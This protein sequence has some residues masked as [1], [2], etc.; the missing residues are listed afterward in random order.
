MKYEL[1]HC[2]VLVSINFVMLLLHNSEEGVRCLTDFCFRVESLVLLDSSVFVN[3]KS[4][5][6]K[7]SVR[8]IVLVIL[9]FLQ[10]IGLQSRI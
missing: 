1:V 9:R 5:F 6:K 2:A 10:M 7:C 3:K 4:S 8:K